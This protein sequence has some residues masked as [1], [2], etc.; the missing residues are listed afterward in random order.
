MFYQYIFDQSGPRQVGASG[1]VV[2][3][4]CTRTMFDQFD[5]MLDQYI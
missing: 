5:H 1:E 4:R 3:L 2:F